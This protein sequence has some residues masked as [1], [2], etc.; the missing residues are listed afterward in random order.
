[1]K[2][3]NPYDILDVFN[4]QVNLPEIG[5]INY[6]IFAKIKRFKRRKSNFR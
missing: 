4:M 3:D 6:Y 5:I 1:M 2:G